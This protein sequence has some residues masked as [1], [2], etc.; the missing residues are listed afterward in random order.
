MG[1]AYERGILNIPSKPNNTTKSGNLPAPNNRLG[2]SSFSI[3]ISP[4]WSGLTYSADNIRPCTK[5][6][7][8]GN[9]F[10][11]VYPHCQYLA[12]GGPQPTHVLILYIKHSRRVWPTL[13]KVDAA[14][15]NPRKAVTQL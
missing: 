1:L 8:L 3:T 7:V 9:R 12:E 6:L 5:P 11:A 2:C 15:L 10:L 4:F 13:T 14:R